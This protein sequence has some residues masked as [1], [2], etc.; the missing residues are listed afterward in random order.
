MPFR[1]WRAYQT[2]L[3]VHPVKTAAFS[4]GTLISLGDVLAQFVVEKRDLASYDKK[5][6]LRFAIFGT[7]FGGPVFSLW[8]TRLATSFGHTKYASLKMVACDQLLFAPPFLAYFLTVME[9]LKGDR[10]PEIKAK[11]QDDYP[12]IIKTNYK[13]WPAVQALNFTFVPVTYRVLVVN[14]VAVGWNTYLAWMSEK[15]H[16][17]PEL[18]PEQHPELLPEQQQE[19]EEAH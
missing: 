2:A 10:L 3:H 19:A 11:L 13:I 8:Y 7:F 14:L 16:P 18:Q 9:L 12:D 5:R 1:L 4:A 17:H 15:V 6:T